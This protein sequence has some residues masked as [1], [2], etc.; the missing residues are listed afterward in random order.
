MQ[1]NIQTSYF[2]L[3]SIEEERLQIIKSLPN[4][5]AAIS[6]EL[7]A[8]KILY[9][10]GKISANTCLDLDS[11]WEGIA[12]ITGE[13]TTSW[14]ERDQQQ[15]NNF[16]HTIT[17]PDLSEYLLKNKLVAKVKMK[18]VGFNSEPV[19]YGDALDILQ[20]FISLGYKGFINILSKYNPSEWKLELKNPRIGINY[21]TGE[22]ELKHNGEKRKDLGDFFIS[23]HRLGLIERQKSRR[24]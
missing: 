22:I 5:W 6:A 10:Q 19:S 24:L 23:L 2:N 4:N 16:S 7:Y 11:T 14:E 12:K 20:N 3:P 13:F 21:M 18:Y 1:S 17:S 9:L 8:P 15:E